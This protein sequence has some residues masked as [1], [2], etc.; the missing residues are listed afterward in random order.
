M[1]SAGGHGDDPGQGAS[2][3]GRPWGMPAPFRAAAAWSWRALLIGAVVFF[4]VLFAVR[5]GLVVLALFAGMLLTALIRPAAE[6]LVRRGLPRL[7]ATWLSLLSLLVATGLVLW[8]IVQRAIVELQTVQFGVV[9][10]LGR[11]RD[12]VVDTTG[13]PRAP[14]EAA[15]QQVADQVTGLFRGGPGTGGAFPIMQ[16]TSTVGAVLAA[17]GLALFS[18]FWFT[19]D[20]ARVWRYVLRLVPRARR[21]VADRAGRGAWVSLGGYLRGV[22]LVALADA[23]GVGVALLL[24]DVPM[25]LGLAALTFVGG[26]VPLIGALVAGLAAVLVALAANG[27]TTALLTLGAVVLVQQIEGQLLAPLIM[28]RS[29]QLHPLVIAYVIAIGGVLYGL[30]GAVV[31]VPLAAVVHTVAGH[32]RGG[33]DEPAVSGAPSG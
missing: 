30:A 9:T 16:T 14:V 10:G 18:A 25:A 17:A 27:V 6:W 33:T 12:L 24:L 22:T 15:L 3:G 4:L 29:V 13:L 32:L 5:I 21:S 8:F 7:A 1:Q 20:G 2:P 19:Y 23:V 26:F 28:G 11:L 31:A